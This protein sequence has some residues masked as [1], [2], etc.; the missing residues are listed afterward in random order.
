M[1]HLI[2]SVSLLLLLSACS[3]GGSR[4]AAIDAA[5]ANLPAPYRDG[6]VTERARAAGTDIVLDIRFAEARVS[7]LADKPELRDALQTDEQNAMGELC[8]DAA[9]SPFLKDN[10]V[11]RR[12]FVDADG[13]LFFEARLSGRDCPAS[14]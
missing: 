14:S 8:T 2:A 7:Q 4:Q 6:L 3:A 12:R 13:E 10:G 1:K 11:V 5:N 9:L